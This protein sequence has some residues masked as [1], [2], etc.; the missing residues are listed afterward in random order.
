M[1]WQK[2]YNYFW[3]YRVIEI[4]FLNSTGNWYCVIT[5][6]VVS[7]SFLTSL[8]YWMILVTF[9]EPDISRYSKHLSDI[10]PKH[11]YCWQTFFY[12]TRY[13]NSA[14]FFLIFSYERFSIDFRFRDFSSFTFLLLFSTT[15]PWSVGA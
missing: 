12:F 11:Y 13:A 8:L 1:Y 15:S 7:S 10:F 9:R 2:M 5:I 3:N 4:G 14:I 6:D